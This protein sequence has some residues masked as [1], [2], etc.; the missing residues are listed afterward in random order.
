MKEKKIMSAKALKKI[1]T[2][3]TLTILLSMVGM[4]QGCD[5]LIP[6]DIGKVPDDPSWESLDPVTPT[7]KTVVNTVTPTPK[8]TVTSVPAG[9]PTATTTPTLSP[10]PTA[11]L[12]TAGTPK[13]TETPI[14]T[15]TSTPTFTPVPTDTPTPS[16]TNTPS[17]T[18]DPVKAVDDYVWTTTEGRLRVD[19]DVNSTL[20]TLVPK[21]TKVH[22]TGIHENG[23]SRL[24]YEGYTG[25]MSY[26]ALTDK[27]TP[28]PSPTNTPTPTNTP[29]PKP[30]ATSTP[31][32]TPT[33]QPTK[34]L[35]PPTPAPGTEIRME[36]TT[37]PETGDPQ[38]TTYYPDGTRIYVI[39]SDEYGTI[40]DVYY[41]DGTFVET[42]TDEE[43]R[44]YKD[45]ENPDGTSSVTIQYKYMDSYYLDTGY[46]NAD[47]SGLYNVRCYYMPRYGN[48]KVFFNY[49]PDG[50]RHLAF[51]CNSDGTKNRFS[52]KYYD[53]TTISWGF[54][55]CFNVNEVDEDGNRLGAAWTTFTVYD[56]PFYD[57]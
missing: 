53:M 44:P 42:Y 16:P 8:P 28:T 52:D 41:P 17:P 5:I 50:N 37:V 7:P 21:N 23:W 18:P 20:L 55:E 38:I 15:A 33:L 25:F 56:G 30:K 1:S 46:I 29:S 3:I 31:K 13:P 22:R 12:E 4:M 27:P 57:Y 47:G 32:V 24:E 48:I 10:T 34:G 39:E 40:T 19:A 2:M 49:P 11:A 14:P 54:G 45:V 9:E 6:L 51:I 36:K 26:K 35:T 43:G